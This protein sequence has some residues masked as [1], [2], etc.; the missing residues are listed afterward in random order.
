MNAMTTSDLSLR[1]CRAL[2]ALS[3]AVVLAACGGGGGGVSVP[4]GVTVGGG[5]GTGGGGT[6]G[7][8][9]GGGGTGGGGTGGGGGTTPPASSCVDPL[10]TVSQTAVFNTADMA[11]TGVTL[12]TNGSSACFTT[13]AAAGV[14]STTSMSQGPNSF[15]YFEATRVSSVAVG[16]GTSN[17]SLLPNNTAGND[18]YANDQALL[19]RDG[20]AESNR[21]NSSLGQVFNVGNETKFGFAVDYRGPNPVV[22]VIGSTAIANASGSSVSN[23]ACPA[24]TDATQPCVFA[25]YVMGSV[26]TPLFIYAVGSNFAGAAEVSINTGGTPSTKPFQYAP[27]KVREAVRKRY[28]KGEVGLNTEWAS[29]AA[30]ALPAIALANSTGTAAASPRARA[31]VRTSDA[32]PYT[33]SFAVTAA[34]GSSVQWLSDTG[35]VLG[36]TTSLPLTSATVQSI[37]GLGT[38]R[39]QAVATDTTTGKLNA[40]EFIVTFTASDSDDDNDGL[41]YTQEQAAGTDPANPDSDG[42]GVSDGV[43]GGLGRSPSVA[44]S[45]GPQ[46]VLRRQSGLGTGFDTAQGVVLDSDQLSIALTSHLNPDCLAGRL[47]SAAFDPQPLSQEQCNKRAIRASEGIKPG[48]FRYY[49]THRLIPN[50]ANGFGPN[51]GQ[52]FI[53]SAGKIDPFCCVAEGANVA[54]RDPR[55]PFSFMLNNASSIWDTLVSIA[56]YDAPNT[57]FVGFAVDYRNTAAP[58]Q[59]YIITTDPSTPSGYAIYGPRTVAGF[60]GD[61]VPF[62]YGHPQSDT[63]PAM[64][65]NFGLRQWHYPIASVRALIEGVSSGAGAAL[66]PGVGV[67]RRP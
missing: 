32:S 39:I 34:A 64:E 41:S 22:Y 8:G 5:G 17:A 48:E 15:Y 57:T 61:A 19:L 3:L 54:M 45:P 66:V 6:G 40:L 11:P 21:T 55:T 58:P 46:V 63:A 51:T 4:E 36:T 10:P 12:S 23:A 9:T 27:A 14:R 25:R 33:A 49:E 20:S 37:V 62:V 16:V 29:T 44:E 2:G 52:G 38:H 42:D 59:A 28:F 30:T 13:S 67:H 47:P 65:I 43:E 56:N 26:T 60:T 18:I 24:G 1:A 35:T 50:N 31:V 7:G 53:T